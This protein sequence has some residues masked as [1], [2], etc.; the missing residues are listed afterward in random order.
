MTKVQTAVKEMISK[1]ESDDVFSIY[2]LERCGGYEAVKKALLRL[3]E[4][5]IITHLSRGLYIKEGKE[6]EIILEK[7]ASAIARKHG[8]T[9]APSGEECINIIGL[10]D[11]PYDRYSYIS[12][13]TYRKYIVKGQTLTF[14][15]VATKDI[16]AL[17]YKAVVVVN[18]L[19]TIGM[20]NI[21]AD[22]R[23]RMSE[24]LTHEDKARLKKE[25]TK[26]TKWVY[27]VILDIIGGDK[28]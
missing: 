28:K 16:L 23:K 5:G 13:G 15:H 7:A 18:A 21:T 24:Y 17:S 19:K 8:W 10:R 27:A 11:I 22:D 14:R 4:S 26:C 3:E 12:S 9:T 1:I 20:N 6:N 25:C 2:D